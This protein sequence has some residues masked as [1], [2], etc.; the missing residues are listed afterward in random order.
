MQIY[1]KYLIFKSIQGLAKPWLVFSPA[2][3]ANP[4]QANWDNG[5]KSWQEAFD[6]IKNRIA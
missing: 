5:V 2:E 3:R 1:T 4:S 6:S